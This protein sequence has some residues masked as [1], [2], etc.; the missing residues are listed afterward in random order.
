MQCGRPFGSGGNRSWPCN[1]F[2]QVN[3]GPQVVTLTSPID[4]EQ[5]SRVCERRPRAPTVTI[6]AWILQRDLAG[7]KMTGDV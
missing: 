2:Q 7:T 4:S 5:L 3:D 6:G 1:L